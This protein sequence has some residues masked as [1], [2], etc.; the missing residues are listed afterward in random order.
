M[1]DEPSDTKSAPVGAFV[2]SLIAGLW[3]LVSS[4]MM[5]YGY[6]MMDGGMLW[7]GPGAASPWVWRHEMMSGVGPGFLWPWAGMI[8]G[9]A[10]M[11]AAITMYFQPSR[12]AAMGVIVLIASGLDI[13]A[14]AGDYL[15]ALLGIVGG[16]LAILWKA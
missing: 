16:V 2:A 12:S 1:S 15:A 8:Y 11:A 3:M 6:H 7:S 14:G 5:T 13:F 4:G 10:T 9:V